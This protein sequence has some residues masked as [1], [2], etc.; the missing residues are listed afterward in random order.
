MPPQHQSFQQQDYYRDDVYSGAHPDNPYT[1]AKYYPIN[2]S[3]GINN[4]NMTSFNNFAS[5]RNNNGSA[6]SLISDDYL[7]QQGPPPIPPPHSLPLKPLAVSSAS[8]SAN[9]PSDMNNLGGNN[10]SNNSNRSSGIGVN[11]SSTSGAI[12]RT[13]SPLRNAMDDVMY[14]LHTL[15]LATS[16]GKDKHPAQ[17]ER[18]D[19]TASF[20]SPDVCKSP[21]IAAAAPLASPEPDSSYMPFSSSSFGGSP[22]AANRRSP[23]REP[24]LTSAKDTD[25]R[26]GGTRSSLL[27][28]LNQGFIDDGK[29]GLNDSLISGD[30]SD[31]EYSSGD[32]GT[33]SKSKTFKDSISG[34][35][36]YS[37]SSLPGLSN[38]VA[39]EKPVDLPQNNMSGTKSI[40]KQFGVIKKFFANNINANSVRMG[41]TMSAAPRHE[42]ANSA[43]VISNN[44]HEYRGR[45]A[46]SSLDLYPNRT[47]SFA[48]VFGENTSQEDQER[49]IEINRALHRTNTLTEAEIEERIKRAQ[50]QLG[51]ALAQ[52]VLEPVEALKQ[53]A[54]NE[55]GDGGYVKKDT[56]R[57]ARY[58][59][60]EVDIE[61]FSASWD[62]FS[63]YRTMMDFV[64]GF[65]QRR[66]RDPIDQLRAAFNFCATKLKWEPLFDDD[67]EEEDDV[68][69]SFIRIMQTRR[70][71]CLDVAL[72]FQEICS[73]LEIPCEVVPG[74]LKGPG[75]VWYDETA[76][77]PN[78]YWNGVIVDGV[79][80]MVDTSLANPSFPTHHLYAASISRQPTST[81]P[82]GA[83]L[84]GLLTRTTRNSLPEHFYFLTKPS[85]FLFTH[86]PTFNNL[87]ATHVIP[88]LG[89]DILLSLPLKAPVAFQHGVSLLNFN[90]ALARIV[91]GRDYFAELLI[92]VRN[93][94]VYL[95]ARVKP[96]NFPIG[97]ACST[98]Y[99]SFDDD[100]DD[101][102]MGGSSAM[103]G[104]RS[105][106][107]SG[108]NALA[109]PFWNR[110]HDRLFYRIKA[111]LPRLYRQGALNIY[112]GMK[113]QGSGAPPRR[114]A[115]SDDLVLALSVPLTSVPD[116]ESYGI[117]PRK[118][119]RRST[120]NSE[121]ES[122]MDRPVQ[123]V[124]RYPLRCDIYI[125]QPQCFN[126]IY[127]HDYMFKVQY[128]NT[129]ALS[130]ESSSSGAISRSLSGGSGSGGSSGS[131]S[132]KIKMALQTPRGRV[133]KMARA[134][135]LEDTWQLQHCVLDLGVWRALVLDAPTDTNWSVYAEWYCI[136]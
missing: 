126:L 97:S 49:W 120:T 58:D 67:D 87:D 26:R 35:T 131:S 82:G 16:P 106:A 88:N 3:N 20:R 48:D 14:S 124:Q 90:T 51:S 2:N 19:S 111:V 104:G 94:N 136:S 101:E 130:N 9:L 8:P 78:H 53:I 118:L 21:A 114:R 113:P 133:I 54:G 99:H 119:D 110:K 10:I 132:H 73:A 22:L 123:F 80:R 95:V 6:F 12:P 18:A 91:D 17:F 122:E 134:Q 38:S 36:R 70:A 108:Q 103:A 62:V 92:K 96:G 135:D 74:Y 127:G 37:M 40:R 59:F 107:G 11:R 15:E 121:R 129:L 66:W 46:L 64:R 47:G 32:H 41:T 30:S 89:S 28:S 85:E 31:D 44:V 50:H 63:Q 128:Y 5:N 68:R 29:L 13:P 25:L 52:R 77:K 71:S 98:S 4:D 117:N 109:Q 33:K 72:F 43:V 55:T 1:N 45:T 65:F 112:V 42:R 83:G 125:R 84:G 24:N 115:G 76:L 34:D 102:V 81:A 116:D 100:D 75:E 93:P 61:V 23:E 60:G 79:W 86:T 57:L 27:E 69:K 7:R 105:D 56:L 39:Y